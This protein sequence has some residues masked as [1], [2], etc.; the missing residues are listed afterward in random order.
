[1]NDETQLKHLHGILSALAMFS[2]LKQQ[3]LKFLPSKGL[4]HDHIQIAANRLGCS[5]MIIR[6]PRLS[7]FELN[8]NKNLEYQAACFSKASLSN[9]TPKLIVVLEPS[10]FLPMGALVVEE[11]KGK[12]INLPQDLTEMAK[13]FAQVHSLEV[14]DNYEQYPLICHSDPI[15][16]VIKIINDQSKFINAVTG[17]SQVRKVLSE[18]I[19][20]ARNFASRHVNHHPP[21]RL[22]LTDTHPGNFIIDTSG[23]V[24]FVDLEKALYGSPAIDLGHATI[25]TSTLWDFDVQAKLSRVDIINFYQAY[26]KFLPINLQD[27]IRPWLLPMRR[28]AWLRSVTWSCKW[29]AGQHNSKRIETGVRA[30]IQTHI[31]NRLAAF[32][33]LETILSI[34]SEWVG[35]NQLVLT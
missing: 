2:N 29:S 10:K 21:P 30:Q 24:Y 35:P 13:C 9:H 5:P 26:L 33:D 25:L 15:A 34:R 1:M 27:E 32:V 7:Q 17:N 16:G 11:I 18:E 6:L 4:V 12:S 22:C 3:D 31:S 20:W 8:P 19:A 23:K 28:L 14:P